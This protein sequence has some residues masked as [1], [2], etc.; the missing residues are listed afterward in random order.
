MGQPQSLPHNKRASIQQIYYDGSKVDEHSTNDGTKKTTDGMAIFD[1]AN[2][3]P[4]HGDEM[5]IMEEEDDEEEDFVVVPEAPGPAIVMIPPSLLDATSSFRDH[6]SLGTSSTSLRF[7]S[8]YLRILDD[9]NNHQLI[10]EEEIRMKP[11]VHVLPSN[12]NA[13][14]T[15]TTLTKPNT[16]T[17]T[18]KAN[19]TTNFGMAVART[20]FTLPALF[21]LMGTFCFSV[22]TILFLYMN[23]VAVETPNTWDDSPPTIAILGATLAVPLLLFGLGSAMSLSWALV[24]DCWRGLSSERSLLRNMVFWDPM[25]TEWICLAVFGGIPLITIIVTTL[26]RFDNWYQLSIGS[27]AIAVLL[28]QTFYMLL[29]F[30][31]E[32]TICAQFLKRYMPNIYDERTNVP[33]WVKLLQTNILLTQQQKYSGVR[34]ERYL[35]SGNALPPPEGF[36]GDSRYFPVQWH[37]KFASR[38]TLDGFLGV[39][40]KTNRIFFDVL[41]PPQRNYSMEEVFGNVMI[42]S[43]HNF[44]LERIWCMDRKRSAA[45]TLTGGKAS[46]STIQMV[47]G[48][49]C[50][51]VSVLVTVLTLAGLLVWLGE[52]PLTVFIIVILVFGCCLFPLVLSSFQVYRFNRMVTTQT[53]HRSQETNSTLDN[54]R[55]PHQ[56]QPAQEHQSLEVAPFDERDPISI[57]K[58]TDTTNI[59]TNDKKVSFHSSVTH[60]PPREE[61][62]TDKAMISVWESVRISE[63]KPWFCWFTACLEI[64][65]FFL[66][67]LVSLYSTGNVPVAIVFTVVGIPSLMRHYFNVSN[68]LHKLGPIDDLNLTSEMLSPALCGLGGSSKI[69]SEEDCKLKNQAL[70]A[71]IVKRVTRSKATGNWII[72]YFL[73]FFVVLVGFIMASN[74]ESF[75]YRVKGVVFA[76]DFYY[77]PQPELPYPT[78][79]VQ[80]G[81]SLPGQQAAAL[82]DYSFLATMSFAAQAEAQ[83]LLNQW[84]GE[85]QVVDDS[86]FVAM[87]RNETGTQDHPVSYKLFTISALPD[88][89]VVSIRGSEA[90]WDWTV[91]I[92]LWAGGVLAQMTKGILPFGW[93]WKPIL[94]YM[95][96][97]INSVQSQKLKEVSYY[98]YTSDFVDALYAGFDGRQYENLRVT[99]A[100]LGGGL[101]ILTGAITGAS[102][103][104]FSGLNAMYSRMTFDPPITEEQLNTRVF[105]V[106]PD[107]DVIA[108]IDEPGMLTQHTQCRGPKNSLFACHSMWRTLCEI[109]YQCGSNGRPINCWCTS[110]FGYP[111]PTSNSSV[112]WEEACADA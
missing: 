57:S 46:V 112:T 61:Q 30:L 17:R 108:H 109:Q 110:R 47:S 94:P 7:R 92:Q 62:S 51:G 99:G 78:C 70:V 65:L 45:V 29:A 88:S 2:D 56:V 80:K 54:E 58:Q 63:M 66:W 24:V 79:S 18:I 8:R 85:N 38:W 49:I 73:L 91:D 32:M 48:H 4:D 72:L 86:E 107:R 39:C 93:M 111:V 71:T 68:L 102:A 84:F 28:F 36:S 35:V 20:F 53:T 40:G 101:A 16:I 95:V 12:D 83:P 19:S 25:L 6:Y 75:D 74:E 69:R 67:P 22:Q 90:L 97:I 89:A 37:L 60:D 87:Y 21:I 82:A 27:W 77:D 50:I 103:I 42:V 33:Q 31:N 44:T 5:D 14:T 96:Y 52:S 59:D 100:S 1:E 76:S 41:D 43:K 104:S 105:N 3:P 64:A 26:S 9:D 11:S 106:I 98:Q 55:V 81:F 34:H 23:I 15:T 13:T 10:L